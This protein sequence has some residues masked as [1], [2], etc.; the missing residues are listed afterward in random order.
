MVKYKQELLQDFKTPS[1]R[2][3]QS[4]V[5]EFDNPV[6]ITVLNVPANLGQRQMPLEKKDVSL[7]EVNV[8]L[9]L[10]KLVKKP[11]LDGFYP[12]DSL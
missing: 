5:S 7:I 6:T 12:S 10:T 4:D 9:V 2:V 11:P 1:P 8:S 3:L